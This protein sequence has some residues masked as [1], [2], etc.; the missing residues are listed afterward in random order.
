MSKPRLFIG[1]RRFSS[2]SLRAWQVLRKSGLDF[3]EVLVPLDDVDTRSTI[4]EISPGGTVPALHTEDGVIWDSLAICEWAAE[5]VPSLWPAS[6]P[7]RHRARSAA[8]AMHAGFFALRQHCPMDLGREPAAIELNDATR[9]DIALM[10]ALWHDV[11]TRPGPYL[12]GE[13]SI[14]D[15]FFTPA[16]TRFRTYAVDLHSEAQAYCDQLLADED[17]LAWEA[18]ALEED[19]PNPYENP[20]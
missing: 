6:A 1:N 17:F 11:A 16:A 3:E 4:S 13:W 2:W 18:G 14:A 8:S 7:L 19:F 10:Q 5:Q 15:A 12:F 20:I 9:M